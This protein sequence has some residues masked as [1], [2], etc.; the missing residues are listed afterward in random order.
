MNYYLLSLAIADLGVL[1]LMY[2]VAVLKY[3]F[4]F[5]WLLGRDA[6]LYMIPTEEIFFGAST[7]SITAIA[8]ERY[9]NVVGA[10]RYQIRYRSRDRVRTWLVIG[11]VWLVSFLVSSAPL[12][13]VM[14]YESTLQICYPS[15]PEVNGT[16]A[17]YMSHSI[18]LIVFW[19]TLPLVVIAFTYIKIKRGVQDSV[20][21][22]KSLTSVPLQIKERR[23]KI[24]LRQSNKARHILTPLVVL[25]AVTMFPLNA[26]RILLLIMPM[27][28][29]NSYYNLIMGQIA[30]FIVINSSANPLVYYLTSNEFKDAFKRIFKSVRDDSFFKSISSKFRASR[31]TWYETSKEENYQLTNNNNPQVE[32]GSLQ[33]VTGL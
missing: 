9:R 31:G 33:F 18:I 29:T 10:K 27:F 16:N 11:M 26:L 6:C 23:N 30:L 12:Y 2:P 22:Q 14:A 17:L 19:Y 13:P 4:P 20:K 21:F 24:I 32:S 7:W 5:R 25:F 3:L 15:W 28:W 8:I 1:L